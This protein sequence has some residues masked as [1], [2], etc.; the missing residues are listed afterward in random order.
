MGDRKQSLLI[1][2]GSL[3]HCVF[4]LVEGPL[5]DTHEPALLDAH[6]VRFTVSDVIAPLVVFER[7]GP[8]PARR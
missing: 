5:I 2:K 4:A 8:V 1:F 3:D 7:D 6:E